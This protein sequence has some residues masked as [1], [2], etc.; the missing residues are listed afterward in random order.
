[1]QGDDAVLPGEVVSLPARWRSVPVEQLEESVEDRSDL[2]PSLGGAAA[3]QQVDHGGQTAQREAQ[4]VRVLGFL[5]RRR[6]SEAP[7]TQH[8]HEILHRVGGDGEQT[9]F[10]RAGRDVEHRQVGEEIS[11]K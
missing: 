1:M 8:G 11:R 2:H 6:W 9:I 4:D 3:L 10:L 7:V 5:G